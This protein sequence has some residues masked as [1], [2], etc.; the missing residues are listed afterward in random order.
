MS[1]GLVG[2]CAVDVL[3]DG[4]SG[5]SPS[6]TLW[7]RFSVHPLDRRGRFPPNFAPLAKLKGTSLPRLSVRFSPR[8][9]PY[10]S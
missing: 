5:D 8:Q 9:L 4:L 2:W 7:E 6:Q 1:A 3:W 10:L